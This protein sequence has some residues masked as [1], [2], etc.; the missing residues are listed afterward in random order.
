MECYLAAW[1]FQPD[2]AGPLF[3]VA[4]HYQNRQLYQVSHLF[5][6]RAMQIPMPG[7]ERL[8]VERPIYEYRL[9][10]E[11]AVACFYVGMHQEAIA[12]NSRLLES[13]MLPADLVEKVTHNRQF[14]LD[15]TRS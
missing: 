13:G 6:S 12:T 8:F 15:K 11:Y 1:Q 7:P 3:R 9:A 10:L 5:L 14:S 2:R 4:M